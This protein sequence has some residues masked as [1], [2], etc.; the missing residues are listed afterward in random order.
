MSHDALRIAPL[1]P[2][3]GVTE[4]AGIAGT[5]PQTI[6]RWIAEGRLRAARPVAAGSSRV[7]IKTADLLALLGLDD[8]DETITPTPARRRARKI[9]PKKD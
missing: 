9:T 6:R 4:A 7:R 3:I 8:A 5:H 2:V 1:P